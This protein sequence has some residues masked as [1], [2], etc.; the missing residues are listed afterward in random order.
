MRLAVPA[1]QVE[2]HEVCML[3]THKAAISARI[4]ATPYNNVLAIPRI[5]KLV[6]LCGSR[7]GH[8]G[9]SCSDARATAS[10][11]LAGSAR[12]WVCTGST[13]GPNEVPVC[14]T[15]YLGAGVNGIWS[16]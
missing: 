16:T 9:V 13:W 15:W 10:H 6:H 1:V 12:E 11:S 7:T 4:C 3:H 14:R 5:G 8:A 2:W